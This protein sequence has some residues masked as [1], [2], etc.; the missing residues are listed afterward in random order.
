MPNKPNKNNTRAI[1][2][3]TEKYEEISRRFWSFSKEELIIIGLTV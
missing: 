1:L 2:N 3:T